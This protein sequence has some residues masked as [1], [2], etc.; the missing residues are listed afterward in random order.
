MTENIQN[1]INI[2]DYLTTLKLIKSYVLLLSPLVL[3]LLRAQVGAHVKVQELAQMFLAFLGGVIY[4]YII[5][6]T[7]TRWFQNVLH[8]WVVV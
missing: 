8:V 6:V 7:N 4:M 3:T 5:L 2:S 1:N